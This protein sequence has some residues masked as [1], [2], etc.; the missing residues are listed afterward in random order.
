MKVKKLEIINKFL[1]KIIPFLSIFAITIF[2]IK[3]KSPLMVV[4]RITF[5]N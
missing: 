4:K 5:K 1:L 2:L 3:V